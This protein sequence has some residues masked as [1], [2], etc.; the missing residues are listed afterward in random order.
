MLVPDVDYATLYSAIAL[1]RIL[2][3][4]NLATVL[5][6]IHDYTDDFFGVELVASTGRPLEVAFDPEAQKHFIVSVY[7][8]KD[9]LARSP[10]SG[11]CQNLTGAVVETKPGVAHLRALEVELN[12]DWQTYRATYHGGIGVGSVYVNQDAS[13]IRVAFLTRV[14]A[15][16]IDG[17]VRWESFHG[18]T[19]HTTI[20]SQRERIFPCETESLPASVVSNVAV[21]WRG[22]DADA[23]DCDWGFHVQRNVG[24]AYD[25]E[26]SP[27]RPLTAESPLQRSPKKCTR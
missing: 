18:L 23:G 19:L 21:K 24:C 5:D 17:E 13:G 14:V 27:I 20:G 15:S 10:W 9:N 2:P 3:P 25:N 7:N 16:C 4:Q 6:V 1:T 26:F 12:A 8:M 22:T 11:L